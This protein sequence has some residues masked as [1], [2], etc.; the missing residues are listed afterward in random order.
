MEERERRGIPPS[1][2]GENMHTVKIKAYAKINLTLEIVGAENGYHAL[3]SLVASVD[4]FDSITLRK[5]KDNLSSVTMRGMGSEGIPPETN[6]ALKAAELFSQRYGVT[7][8]D[9][10][11]YK[12][13][14]MGAGLGGSSADAAGVLCGMAKLYSVEDFE[15]LGELADKLGSDT[16]YMLRGGYARM[17][18]RGTELAYKDI[19]RTLYLL[20]LFPNGSVNTGACYRAYDEL[21]K[22]VSKGATE[23]CLHALEQ[24]DLRGVGEAMSNDLYLPAASLNDEVKRAYDEAVSFAPLGVTMTGSGSCVTALFETRELCE[25]AK[26]RYYGNFKTAVVKTVVPEKIKAWRNPFA[27]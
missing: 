17:C 23:A 21:G 15:G 7:G 19:E 5:R 8:A 22:T 16:K 25:W 13:I 27:L 3:D 14:P 11:V 18:G 9:I 4:I 6:N 1:L 2:F 24:G 26:S 20:L 12:N 10:T